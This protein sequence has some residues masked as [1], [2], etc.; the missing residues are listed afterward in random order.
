[1]AQPKKHRSVRVAPEIIEKLDELGLSVQKLLD[2]KINEMFEVKV[3]VCLKDKRD[4]K[5]A[6]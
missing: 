5:E 6:A 1:M 2:E 3:V 4:E